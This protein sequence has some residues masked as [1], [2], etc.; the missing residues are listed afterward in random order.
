VT[1]DIAALDA[2]IG[3]IWPLSLKRSTGWCRY[4]G[5]G[6]TAAAIIIAEIGVDM[7]RFPTPAHLAEWASS[8]PESFLGRQD[9]G[10]GSAGHGNRYLARVLGEAAVCASRTDT[11]RSLLIRNGCDQAPT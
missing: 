1:A 5:V 9:Q 6:P 11:F 8:H 7:S 3:T 4:Q 2:K 10:N